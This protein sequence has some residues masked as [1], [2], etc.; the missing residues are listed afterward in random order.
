M[1]VVIMLIETTYI[2][3]SEIIDRN[4][5]TFQFFCNLQAVCLVRTP[6]TSAQPIFRSVSNLNGLFD[7]FVRHEQGNRSKDCDK[8]LLVS[9]TAHWRSLAHAL[10]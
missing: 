5:S 7:G 6:N 1:F 9:F 8:I 10:D 3:Y 4:H 2:E